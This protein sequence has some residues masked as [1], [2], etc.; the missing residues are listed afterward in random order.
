MW[1]LWNRGMVCRIRFR[2]EPRRQNYMELYCTQNI[3]ERALSYI[4]VE[5][6]MVRAVGGG[7]KTPN[8]LSLHLPL[9]TSA[10]WPTTCVFVTVKEAR[11]YLAESIDKSRRRLQT[12]L[13][14]R[15]VMKFFASKCWN[16]RN[17]IQFSSTGTLSHTVQSWQRFV[18]VRKHMT[19]S[20]QKLDAAA[21]CAKLK[22][23]S[24]LAAVYLCWCDAC[25]SWRIKWPLFVTYIAFWLETRVVAVLRCNCG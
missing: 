12:W 14:G 18:A 22:A 23:T 16:W 5:G 4:R 8:A 6:T 15:A 3:C 21:V 11:I 7:G 24:R 25:E 19:L 9:R 17:G 2:T 10:C 1:T 13:P 20:A